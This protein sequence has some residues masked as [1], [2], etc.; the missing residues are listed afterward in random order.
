MRW[1]KTTKKCVKMKKKKEC[2]NEKKKKC[3][4]KKEK[5]VRDGKENKIKRWKAAKTY[6]MFRWSNLLQ[7]WWTIADCVYITQSMLEI[8]DLLVYEKKKK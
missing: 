3:K 2:K 4:M 7:K 6:K 5:N 1:N 8:L